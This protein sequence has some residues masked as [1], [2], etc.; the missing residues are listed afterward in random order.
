MKKLI[1]VSLV[2]VLSLVPAFA[3]AQPDKGGGEFGCDTKGTQSQSNNGQTR[4]D[5]SG[6]NSNINTG[7]ASPGT[8]PQAGTP[9][10]YSP[11]PTTRP[12]T[13]A[14]CERAHGTWEEMQM[15]CTLC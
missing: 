7:S 14:D 8:M 9:G 13:K 4:R 15:K 6:T 11:P 5:S 2:A 1:L 12:I 10:T 3:L